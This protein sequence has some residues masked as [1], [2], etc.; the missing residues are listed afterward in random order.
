[1]T[2]ARHVIEAFSADR[3]RTLRRERQLTQEQL[4]R[5]IAGTSGSQV[6]GERLKILAYEKGTRRPAAK[7]LHALAAALDVNA[8]DLLDPHAPM[9]VELLRAIRNLTQAQVAQHLGISQAR[10]SYLESGQ[11]E[12]DTGRREQLAAL[13]RVTPAALA[14]LLA[15]RE[16][17]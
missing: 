3:L 2:R 4:A 16:Q 17:E 13:L 14:Q 15:A 7:A 1:M 12:L 5:R 9:T 11:G 6:D 8:P 10:Y